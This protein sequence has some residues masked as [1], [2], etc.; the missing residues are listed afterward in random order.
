[1]L[2][3]TGFRFVASGCA[4]SRIVTHCIY[5]YGLVCDAHVGSESVRLLGVHSVSCALFPAKCLGDSL[6]PRA[7]APLW[8]FILGQGLPCNPSKVLREHP[9]QSEN[10]DDV[11]GLAAVAASC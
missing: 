8:H 11:Y 7:R 6:C 4:F 3:V 10:F 1:M 2:V 5:C 9:I